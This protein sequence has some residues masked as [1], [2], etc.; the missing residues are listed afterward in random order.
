MA[1]NILASELDPYFQS[2]SLQ[3]PPSYASIIR[4]GQKALG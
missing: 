4:S 1:W 2:D 3:E